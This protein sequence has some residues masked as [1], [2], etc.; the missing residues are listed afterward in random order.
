MSGFQGWGGIRKVGTISGNLEKVTGRKA[1]LKDPKGVNCTTAQSVMAR[2]ASD[3]TPWPES[4]QSDGCIALLP[5]QSPLP[6]ML[7]NVC[8]FI[9]HGTR[10]YGATSLANKIEAS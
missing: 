7:S 6:R 3:P 8:P 2:A 10:S 1:E 4:L 9:V 5:V